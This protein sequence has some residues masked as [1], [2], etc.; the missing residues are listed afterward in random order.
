MGSMMVKTT[1]TEND[2]PITGFDA[3]VAHVVA[4]VVLPDERDSDCLLDPARRTVKNC[5]IIRLLEGA[6]YCLWTTNGIPMVKCQFC[7]ESSAPSG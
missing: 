7:H 1:S 3:E 2:A 5:L 4:A 6:L